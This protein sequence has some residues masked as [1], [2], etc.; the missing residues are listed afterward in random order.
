MKKLL[1]ILVK[2]HQLGQLPGAA[3]SSF[4]RVLVYMGYANFSMIAAM[5]YATFSGTLL[6]YIPWLTFKIF[7]AIMVA[8]LLVVMLL[9]YKFML[10]SEW[11]FTQEQ[12]WRHMNPTRAELKRMWEKLDKIEKKIAGGN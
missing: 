9:D 6:Q 3:K 11:S 8:G 1:S 12:M 7:L 10:P 4:G 5:S 2:Q